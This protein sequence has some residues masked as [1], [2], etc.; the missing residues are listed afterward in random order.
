M[1]KE[2]TL[3][4]SSFNKKFLLFKIVSKINELFFTVL[5][6]LPVTQRLASFA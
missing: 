1:E 3:V 5:N 4:L 2:I 6:A